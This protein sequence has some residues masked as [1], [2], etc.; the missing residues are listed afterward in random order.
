[1]HTKVSL[2]IVPLA[3]GN[4]R[5]SFKVHDQHPDLMMVDLR[6]TVAGYKKF[7]DLEDDI[8][9]LMKS[10]PPVTETDTLSPVSAKDDKKLKIYALTAQGLTRVVESR[11][12]LYPQHRASK[13][14]A[15]LKE[16]KVCVLLGEGSLTDEGYVW[17]Y[18]S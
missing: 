11:D 9:S 15:I 8:V 10:L 4:L 2:R 1:M 3:T 5:E 16:L 13:C 7:S 14:L 12:W 18:I 6:K 17:S